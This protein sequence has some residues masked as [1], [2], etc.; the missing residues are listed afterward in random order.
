[1][2]AT[3]QYIQDNMDTE[4]IDTLWTKFKTDLQEAIEKYVPHKKPA[5][6]ETDPH[7]YQARSKCC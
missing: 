5:L 4:S 1:M 7:G 2:A 3:N 6:Q